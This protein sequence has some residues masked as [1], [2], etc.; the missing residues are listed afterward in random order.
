MNEHA[1]QCAGP[2][3]CPLFGIRQGRRAWEVCQ[4]KCPSERP[5]PEE[6]KRL[7]LLD[8]WYRERPPQTGDG[9]GFFRK[10]MNA[11]KAIARAA[12]QAVKGKPILAAPE[13]AEARKA[14]CTAN[15]CGFYRA[16][17]DSCSH[18]RCGCTLSRRLTLGMVNRP[19]KTEVATEACPIGLWQREA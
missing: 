7:A 13:V 15:T 3:D 14:I 12:G 16:D 5:C 1:C 10:A 9:P 8:R 18:R 2:G 11:G 6:D 4:G 19:G 17:S